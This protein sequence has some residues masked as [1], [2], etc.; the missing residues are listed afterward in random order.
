MKIK[1]KHLGYLRIKDNMSDIEV[2]G[3]PR[4]GK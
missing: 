4:M 3:F 2:E 1:D